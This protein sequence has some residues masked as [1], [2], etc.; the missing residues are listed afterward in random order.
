MKLLRNGI[1]EVFQTV[2][3]GI[4]LFLTFFTKFY[5]LSTISQL[6]NGNMCKS[7]KEAH[8]HTTRTWSWA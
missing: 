1:S 7:N 2:N 8:T 5:P 4:Y 6:L 3:T